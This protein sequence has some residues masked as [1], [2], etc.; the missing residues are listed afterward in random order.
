MATAGAGS[1]G[2]ITSQVWPARPLV[3]RNGGMDALNQNPT[4]SENSI[5]GT[6]DVATS[7][8]TLVAPAVK[9]MLPA[10]GKN[11]ESKFVSIVPGTAC[12]RSA[13]CPAGASATMVDGTRSPPTTTLRL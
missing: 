9:L 7:K 8:G 13:A 2:S 4:T 3:I 10:W 11:D 1:G 5:F 12:S 6:E